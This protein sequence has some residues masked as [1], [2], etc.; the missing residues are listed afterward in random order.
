MPEEIKAKLF[1]YGFIDKK[2]LDICNK[3]EDDIFKRFVR[4]RSINFYGRRVLAPV[5][6][7]V[8]HSAFAPPFRTTHRGVETPP[9]D[10]LGC[11]VLFKYSGKSSPISMWYK[12]GFSCDC[13][14]AYSI[15]F[16]IS[17]K[18]VS[19]TISCAGGHALSP[20]EKENFSIVGNTLL[21]KSSNWAFLMLCHILISRKFFAFRLN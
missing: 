14:V 17:L 1:S 10:S 4:E 8:N 19:F 13:I 21:I 6:E 11:E 20:K 12:Y 5:W 15:P 3:S 9:T 2:L 7:F 16:K 18:G